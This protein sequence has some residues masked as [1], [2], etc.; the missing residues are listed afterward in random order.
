MTK[1]EARQ[2]IEHLKKVINHHRYLYAVLDRSEISDAALDSLKKELFD[3]EQ[4]FPDLVT[5]D[6]PTQRVAGKPL[7]EFVKVRHAERMTSFNDAFSE[8]DMHDW[9]ERLENYLGHTLDSRAHPAP[10]FYCEL[11]IDGLAVELEY[12]NGVFVRGSTRGDGLIG[13]DVTQNL[14]TIEAIPLQLLP[15]DEVEKNLK[16][17]SPH[18]SLESLAPRHI[19]IRGEVFL[20]K[21]E[22]A[23][24]NKE[25]EKKGNKI[26]ANPRNVAAGSIRQLD[27]KIT[28]SRRL[29]SF[30]YDIVTDLGQ[31][32]HEEEHA[33]LR[34]F[35][36]KTNPNNASA[37]DIKEVFIFRNDWAKHRE[38]LDYEIDGVVIIANDNNIFEKAGIIGKAPRAAIAYKFSPREATTIVEDIKVQVGR[39]GALTPVAVMRPVNVG[40]VTIA[41][42]SLHNADEIER[43]GLKIG[44]TVIVSRAGD[45]IPQITKVLKELRTG[46]EKAF[47]MPERCPVDGSRVVREGAIARCSSKTCAAMHRE[48]L[49]HLVSRGAFNIEGLGPKIIDKFLDEGLISDA[50]DMFTLQK[51]DIAALERFGEKSAENIV[52]E[53]AQKKR[54]TLARFLYALGIL[55]VGEETANTLAKSFFA[56]SGKHSTIPIKTILK[57]FEHASPDDLEKVQDIG[58]KVARSI[59]DWFHASR[60]IKFLERLEK[61]GVEVEVE[62]HHAGGTKLAGKSFVLTGTIA[63][64]SREEA[65]EKI[66]ALGGDVSESVSKKTSYVV[67]GSEPGSKYEKAKK[68][69]VKTIDEKEFTSMLK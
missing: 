50:A 51:G 24:I 58:P 47:K 31:K 25:Q 28:A 62:A 23:K 38:K 29:D 45:V 43:L 65:K 17:F 61:A 59:Y 57:T 63:S 27:P 44:D 35:G 53:T 39:T 26:Y 46:K 5:P 48:T 11:K 55:H 22:F 34:A 9:L 15:P 64:L 8:E 30:Q 40:G 52:T 12:E 21:K 3:L 60:N 20:T 42:A 37:K 14:R 18:I 67:V 68:L 4:E 32:T 41:H 1:S 6:S 19:I 13:E 16:K 2:R 66:R 56:P 54:V 36:F 33:F 69:G 49:Y 10:L 7:K